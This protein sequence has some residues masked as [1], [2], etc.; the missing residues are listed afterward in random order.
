MSRKS[1]SLTSLN[2]L[3]LE[4]T[5]KTLKSC[6]RR[7]I[8][9]FMLIQPVGET[10]SKGAHKRFNLKKLTYDERKEKLIE[11]LNALNAAAGGADDE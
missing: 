6:T 3:K 2:T 9:P 5:H 11:R 1:I 10:A 8:Q 7:C 4:L